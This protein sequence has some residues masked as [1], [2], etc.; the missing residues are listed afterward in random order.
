MWYNIPI[1]AEIIK[2]IQSISNPFFDKVFQGITM[3]GEEYFFIIVMTLI[4]WCIDK[5]LGYRIGFAFL[6][7]GAINGCVKSILKVPRPIGEPGIRSLR[8]ETAPGYSFPSGHTQSAATFW[9][10][11]MTNL[12]KSWAYI[13][14]III[15]IAVGVSRLYLGVHRPVDVLAGI[16]LGFV[17]VFISNWMVNISER[18]GNGGIFLIFI[19]PMLVGLYFLRY[20]DYYKA[21]GTVL[22]FYIGYVIE[23]RYINYDVDADILKQILKYIIGVAVV[24]AIKIFVKK[25]LP[26]GIGWDFLRYMFMGLWVTIGAPLIFKKFF[27]SRR[28]KLRARLI[29]SV[30]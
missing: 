28:K 24:I 16:M 26:E 20:P 3:L 7:G 5:K 10:V 23:S 14:G 21:S 12:R 15:I 13:I 22:G 30:K 19:I 27:T 1:N 25:L 17:W 2:A 18:T 6:P 9:A 29:D 8:I 4:Y 11:L